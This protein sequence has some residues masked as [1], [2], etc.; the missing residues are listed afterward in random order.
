MSGGLGVRSRAVDLARQIVQRLEDASRAS[1]VSLDF[2][3]RDILVQH[4]TTANVWHARLSDIEA[5]GTGAKSTGGIVH[6]EG[7]ELPCRL[8]MSLQM[9]AVSMAC[10]PQRRSQIGLAIVEQACMSLEAHGVDEGVWAKCHAHQGPKCAWAVSNPK[11]CERPPFN[12]NGSKDFIQRATGSY[13]RLYL[14]YHKG[15]L[16]RMA[17]P[18]SGAGSSTKTAKIHGSIYRAWILNR[19]ASCPAAHRYDREVQPTAN[20]H[21]PSMSVSHEGPSQGASE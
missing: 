15:S 19:T 4:D 14:H 16:E 9:L 20:S 18:F 7:L 2:K 17:G 6:D 21:K 3:L 8:L 11:A 12:V 1:L 13:M 5:P 10:G